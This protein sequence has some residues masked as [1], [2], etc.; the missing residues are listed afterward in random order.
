MV[1]RITC[2]EFDDF[3]HDY[4]ENHLTGQQRALFESHLDICAACRSYLT[5]YRKTIALCHE[6]RLN[7][8]NPVPETVP[9]ALIQA[10]LAARP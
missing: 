9:D 2:R 8:E 4:E 3:L 6:M 10:I 5:E 7:P 1:R